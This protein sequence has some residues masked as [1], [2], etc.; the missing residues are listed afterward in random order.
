MKTL[1][2]VVSVIVGLGLLVFLIT[3]ATKKRQRADEQFAISQGWSYIHRWDD[4]QDLTGELTARL[5]RVCPEKEFKPSNS[6][7]VETGARTIV[8]FE[9]EY[10]VRDWGPKYN[11]GF[12]CVIES[13][14]F[15]SGNTQADISM[16]NALDQLLLSHKVDMGDSDFGRTF[17]VTAKDADAARRMVTPEFRT[18]MVQSGW[19]DNDY[20]EVSLGPGGAVILAAAYLPSDQWVALAEF[21]RQIESACE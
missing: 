2:I 15:Q 21:A 8:L 19:A 3:R 12:A 11:R 18:L 4:P 20:H 10:R 9:T 14:R 7:I 13:S 6:I 5:K 16:R 1:V 17:L